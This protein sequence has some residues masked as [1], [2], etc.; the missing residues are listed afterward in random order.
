MIN[1]NSRQ[2]LDKNK[3]PDK[4]NQYIHADNVGHSSNISSLQ[5]RFTQ[6][7]HF[8][9]QTVREVPPWSEDDCHIALKTIGTLYMYYFGARGKTIMT[10]IETCRHVN[11]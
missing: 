10:N 9:S 11:I 2:Q 5:L 8:F 4:K 7:E 3:D 6:F 1:E